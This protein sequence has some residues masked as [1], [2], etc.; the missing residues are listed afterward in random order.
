MSPGSLLEVQGLLEL[1]S[2]PVLYHNPQNVSMN[3]LACETL[4]WG[5]K[6]K[7]ERLAEKKFK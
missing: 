3:S 1:P 2:Q 6:E 7:Q 5:F 4:L